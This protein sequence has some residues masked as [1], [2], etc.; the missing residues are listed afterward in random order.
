MNLPVSSLDRLTL[1]RRLDEIG[2]TTLDSS[3]E[4]A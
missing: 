2:R 1:K 3:R 4:R